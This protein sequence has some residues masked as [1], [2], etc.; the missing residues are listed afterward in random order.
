MSAKRLRLRL[1]RHV[2]C[3]TE[4]LERREWLTIKPRVDPLMTDSPVYS[5]I[6]ICVRVV[7]QPGGS[8]HRAGAEAIWG[9]LV[10]DAGPDED[11]RMPDEASQPLRNGSM[12]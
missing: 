10:A 9:H 11:P 7:V 1:R 4:T 5:T 6:R 2:R 12:L 3:N 8:P